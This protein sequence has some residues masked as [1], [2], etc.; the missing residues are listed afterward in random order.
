MS[1]KKKTKKKNNKYKVMTVATEVAPYVNVGGVSRVIS[2]LS[3]ALTKLNHEV[4]IFIPKFGFLDEEKY[5]LKMV[6][7]GLKVPTD[8]ENNP[9]LICNVK[10]T[11]HLENQNIKIY[12][13]EN[14]EYYEK[15]AN[16]YNYSDDP[17]R[18][19][20]L[21]RG[22]LEFIRTKTFVPDIVHHHD[23]QTGLVS[24]YLKTV[25]KKD[26]ILSK[27]TSVF[28][29]HNLAYQ[30]VFD[31]QYVS[32]LDYDD[33]K[34]AVA[35]F[36]VDRIN[37]QNFM[38]RGILY[39]DIINT[40]SRTY[41][42]EILT[43]EFGAGLDSLLLELKGK[44]FGIV[45]GI[46]YDEFNPE[47]DNLIEQNYSVKK[48]D[49]RVENK[50]AL[51]KE[52]DLKVDESKFLMGFVGR[53]DQQKGVDLMVSVLHKVLK[54]FDVQFVQV[55]GGDGWIAEQLRNLKETFPEKVGIHPYPNFTLP[56][57]L[58]AGTDVFLQP[59]RFEPCGITQ[60]EALRYGSI[61]IVRKVGGLNDTVEDFDSAKGR[62]NGF[63][64]EEF[65]D[66]ALFGQIVRAME[67]YRNKKLWKVLMTNAMKSDYSWGFSAKEYIKLYERGIKFKNKKDPQEKSI[68][69]LIG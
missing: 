59:S 37:T 27:I 62:G 66:F 46:D 56:R 36:F 49:L 2:H 3:K 53:L 63:V 14:Q 69:Y 34:S 9:E 55:G 45:D 68:E 47:T 15:R 18:F 30:G 40:V 4:A 12:F 41:S 39:A 11:N 60:I 7:E 6:V 25:Y 43:P 54:N 8:D 16:V 19:A 33:G 57:M 50:R 1:P 24:N 65:D 61:P 38:R 10:T 5:K 26:K 52:F 32:E 58:F 31:P 21:S 51:Q 17:T 64:F 22:A 13:L 28:T 23:W 42:R 67:I 35:S 29:I 48:L 44:L 20:L